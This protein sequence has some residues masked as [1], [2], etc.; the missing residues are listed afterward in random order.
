MDEKKYM[1]KNKLDK[2]LEFAVQK[3]VGKYR[4]ENPGMMKRARKISKDANGQVEDDDQDEK[5]SEEDEDELEEE[6][7]EEEDQ[8]EEIEESEKTKRRRKPTEAEISRQALRS[9]AELLLEYKK[10]QNQEADQ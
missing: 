8:G 4:E 9:V 7:E 2:A 3:L 1:E 6:E 5:E 10:S